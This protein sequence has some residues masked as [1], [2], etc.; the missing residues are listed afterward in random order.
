MQVGARWVLG[1]VLAAASAAC[2]SSDDSGARTPTIDCPAGQ[3]LD[4]TTNSCVTSCKDDERA[5]GTGCTKVGWQSCPSGFV[6]DSSGYGCVDVSPPGDCPAGMMPTIGSTACKPVGTTSCATGFAADPSGWGCSAVAPA[7]SCSGATMETLGSAS[8]VP[9]G[10]CAAAFPPAAATLFVSP[11]ATADATHFKTIAAALAVA[12]DGVT[13]AV[14]TGAYA[15]SLTLGHAVHL[16]G[17]CAAQVTITQA[18]PTDP[19][20]TVGTAVAPTVSGVSISSHLVGVLVSA[21]GSL[22]LANVVVDGNSGGGIAVVGN[23]THVELNGSV[24]R[25]TKAQTTGTLT[26]GH[27]IDVGNGAQ[28]AIAKSAIVGN[29]EIGLYAKDPGSKVTMTS[30][31]VSD[32]LMNVSSALGVG[33]DVGPSAQC[34]VTAS[35]V[36]RNHDAGLTTSA[37]AQLHVA[38]SVVSGTLPSAAGFG[39]GAT[40]DGGNLTLEESTLFGNADLGISAET[41]NGVVEVKNTVI[42][43]TVA[44]TD[45]VK[46][47]GVA[48]STGGRVTLTGVALVGNSEEGVFADGAGAVVTMTDS[49]ARDG[50][51]LSSK[52]TGNG[53]VAQNGGHLVLTGSALVANHESGLLLFDPGTAAE[54]TQ[55][56]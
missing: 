40:V 31:V 45:H 54:V 3:T 18:T 19:G 36:A 35:L 17:K 56:I 48:A 55:S 14:D 50:V 52:T 16:V 24:V 7:S 38:Q 6:P 20:I 39:R 34:D 1:L 23:G 53:A 41:K 37:T 32:T 2:G 26:G 25:G 9:V 4:P 46:G 11:T 15:E 28:M 51:M 10:D 47:A 43:G 5:D 42:R 29:V 33:I 44:N 22:T 12:T 13:I 21:G 30:S 27:G 8:C 49:I